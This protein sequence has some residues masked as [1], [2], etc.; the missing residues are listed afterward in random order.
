MLYFNRTDI[1]TG[2]DI[3]K[4]ST[5]NECDISHYWHFLDKGFKFQPQVCYECHDVLMMSMN[6]SDIAILKIH[7]FDCRCVING[8]S[9][10]EAMGLF[11]NVNPNKKSRRL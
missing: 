1:S 3:Y 10:T 11:N 9:K 5:P 6:L 4:T 8:I 2:I 7:G